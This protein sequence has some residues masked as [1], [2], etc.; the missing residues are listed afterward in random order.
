MNDGSMSVICNEKPYNSWYETN[1]LANRRI[2]ATSRCPVSV[3]KR[4][5]MRGNWLRQM[6]ARA[7]AV[8]RPSS[9]P[10][11]TNSR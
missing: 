10:F 7:C 11:S 6:T 2:P 5:E 9:A 8:G 1:T 3:S 4:A